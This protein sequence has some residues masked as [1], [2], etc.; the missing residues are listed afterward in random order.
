MFGL[1]CMLIMYCEASLLNVGC[2]AVGV[3]NMVGCGVVCIQ[4]VPRLVYLK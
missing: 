1:G 4:V 3:G 2:R